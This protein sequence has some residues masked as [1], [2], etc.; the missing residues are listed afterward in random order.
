MCYLVETLIYLYNIYICL[1]TERILCARNTCFYVGN[2]N[3]KFVRNNATKHGACHFAWCMDFRERKCKTMPH[4]EKVSF[5]YAMYISEI[6]L[7]S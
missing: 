3:L 6:V 7:F 4:T 5:R 2:L 1:F